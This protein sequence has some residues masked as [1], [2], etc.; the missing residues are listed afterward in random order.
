MAGTTRGQEVA[1]QGEQGWHHKGRMAGTIMGEGLAPLQEQ[2]WHH[3]GSRAKR[4]PGRGKWGE[5]GS[6][7]LTGFALDVQGQGDA[8]VD[9]LH[10]F[11]EILLAELAGGQ[12][13]GTWGWSS[14]EAEAL[15]GHQH[16]L[17]ESLPPKKGSL[18][19]SPS[20]RLPKSCS[21]WGSCPLSQL[22]QA[23]NSHLE[24]S[25]KAETEWGENL[26]TPTPGGSL[27]RA[28]PSPRRSPP[29]VSALLSPGHVFLL[30]V[31]E[32]SSSTRSARAPSMPLGRRSTST[33]W[34]SVPPGEKRRGVRTPEHPQTPLPP[35]SSVLLP[36]SSSHPTAAPRPSRATRPQHSSPL[37][38]PKAAWSEHYLTPGCTH[39]AAA[40]VPWPWHSSAPAGSTP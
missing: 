7:S 17:P 32:T 31:M 34:L 2:G 30:A 15:R 3:N 36:Q 33:R 27:G 18:S 11:L 13:R 1:P 21:P 20:L 38:V 8:L 12:S 28:C 24:S 10:D 16:P 40:P 22:K 29:G 23:L 25:E 6:P 37:L 19:P 26:G 39:A 35:L 9:E 14:S 4:H 5:R